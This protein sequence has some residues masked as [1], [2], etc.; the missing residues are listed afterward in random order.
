MYLPQQFQ[1]ENL[2]CQ[3]RLMRENPF[4]TVIT[5]VDGAPVI[6]HLPLM[7]QTRGESNLLIGHLAR[8]NPQWKTFETAEVTAIFYGPDTYITP[9]WYH[10]RQNVP[11]WNY[12]VVHAS[13]RAR[14]IHDFEGIEEILT[15]TV[16][17][18]ERSEPHPWSYQL[19]EEFRRNLVRAIVGFEIVIERLEGKF[20]LSQNRTEEDRR[21]VM[22]GLEARPDEMS[23]KV[24]KMMRQNSSS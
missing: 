3:L 15:R 9:S 20:K 18:M 12:A 1:P 10:D 2:E 19:D 16:T 5:V 14:L 6:N 23:R 21:G 11:T 8:A 24:L 22:A 4:A 7:V 17:E 13:G